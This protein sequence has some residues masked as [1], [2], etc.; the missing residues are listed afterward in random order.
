[1][2]NSFRY[3]CKEGVQSF[4]CPVTQGLRYSYLTVRNQTGD[5]RLKDLC[6]EETTYPQRR[7]GRFLCNDWKLNRIYECAANTLRC[8]SLDT[9]VDCPT[10]EQVFWVGD[11]RVEALVDWTLN[12]DARLWKRCLFPVS[13]THLKIRQKRHIDKTV[14]R[15][16][17]AA[18]KHVDARARF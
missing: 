10:Y 9:Y 16:Q 18:G 8:C 15:K 13:Y 5:V 1:M 12:G 17:R 3:V 2:N 14:A 6:V 4:C 11:A 7:K